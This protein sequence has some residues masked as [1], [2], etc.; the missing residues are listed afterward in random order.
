MLCCREL[1]L[2]RNWARNLR[3]FIKCL[4]VFGATTPSGPGRPHS[5]GY[6]I[7]HNDAPHSVGLLWTSDQLVHRDI[8]LT[9]YTTLT[10]EKRPCRRW[11]SNPQFQQVSVRSRLS[12]RGHWDRHL[13]SLHLR[14][15]KILVLNRN[16][17]VTKGTW[18][19]S[20]SQLHFILSL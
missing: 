1:Y 9:T 5:R 16:A 2:S 14:K 6:W 3:S 19:V 20:T 7:T 8:Y 11:D 15:R 10:T 17:P 18:P 4:F 12:P 13:L